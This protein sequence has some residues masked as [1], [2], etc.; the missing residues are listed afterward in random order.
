MYYPGL[1]TH[2]NHALARR[3]PPQGFG[4]IVSL[5]L[6]DDSVES[7]TR[8]VTAT[9]LFKLAVSLGGPKSLICHSATMTHESTPVQVRR[10]AGVADGLVRLSVGLEEVEDLLAD[11]AQALTLV[12]RGAPVEAAAA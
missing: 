11:L 7:A 6:A 5:V 1:E 9:R 12:R 4:G 10:A 3:Q 8:F 2:P